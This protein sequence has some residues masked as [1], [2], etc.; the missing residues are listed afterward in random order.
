[1]NASEQHQR[2]RGPDEEKTMRNTIFKAA[3][4]VIGAS[5]LWLAAPV[6]AAPLH[7]SQS[8]QGVQASVSGD[9][10]E[11]GRRNDRRWEGRRGYRNGYDGGRYS[12]GEPV[13]RNTR[14]WRGDDGRYYCRKD[15][16]TTGLLIGA[17]VGGLAGHEIA[18]QGDRT[19]G[20]LLG[21]VGGGLL[22]R[23][24]DKDGMRC[25]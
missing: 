11:H 8:W 4:L 5:G 22:G 20:A 3:A 16:G 12:R 13:Y 1:M 24:I 17:A 15:N 18:G 9:A 6:S 10:W 21:A 25:R 14:V 23:A 7:A 19:L 2:V